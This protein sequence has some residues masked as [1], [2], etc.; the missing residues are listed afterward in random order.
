MRAYFMLRQNGRAPLEDYLKK[1]KDKRQNAAIEAAIETLIESNGRIPRPLTAHVT[2][3]IWEL[4]TRLGNR[5][6]YFIQQ[7][8]DIILLD[9]YT[10]KRNRIEK[11]MLTRIVNLY[12]E[13]LI[14]KNKKLY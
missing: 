5:V 1:I 11:R 10:K 8:N 6:F 3:K 13:Y 2:G 9:G 4:R 12:E 14:T 7:G